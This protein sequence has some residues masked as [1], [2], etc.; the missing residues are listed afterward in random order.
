MDFEPRLL[1]L[2]PQSFF[3]AMKPNGLERFKK[4]FFFFS[5]NT[6]TFHKSTR[7]RRDSTCLSPVIIPNKLADL[8]P[9]TKH[10]TSAE[11]YILKNGP[12]FSFSRWQAVLEL[13]IFVPVLVPFMIGPTAVCP[14]LSQLARSCPPHR[15]FPAFGTIVRYKLGIQDLF[16]LFLSFTLC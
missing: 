15:S 10:A 14:E 12:K 8:F 16:A 6:L 2:K 4:E 7:K 5:R 1:S 9:L 11:A 3:G 13:L